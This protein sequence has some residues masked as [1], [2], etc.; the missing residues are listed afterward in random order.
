MQDL[1]HIRIAVLIDHRPNHRG[2]TGGLVGTW[3]HLSRAAAGRS[4]IHL[5]LFFLGDQ[6][7]VIP[8][9]DNVTHVL[10]PPALGTE[11]FFF[12]HSIPTHTD[13]APFHPRLYRSLR[14]YHLLH[15]TD[16]FHAFAKT[17]LW[18]HRISKIPL[19]TSIHTDVIAWARI[20]TPY[21]LQRLIPSSM[22]RKLVIERIRLLDL[23]QLS[24]TRR[25]AGHLRCCRGVFV[26]NKKDMDNVRRLSPRTPVYFLRRG[27]DLELFSPSR[28]DRK[29]LHD[30]MGIPPQRKLLLFV[31][32]LDPVKGAR[33]AAQVTKALLEKGKDVHLLAVG[34][35]SQKRDLVEIL[36]ERVTLTGNLPQSELG[37]IY[38]SSDL[39]LFPSEAEVWPNVVMEAR[40]CGL[41][42]VA[43][44]KG[45]NHVMVGEGVDGILLPTKEV[46]L[47]IRELN[48][49]LENP[50]LLV[51][52]RA[53]ARELSVRSA[54][55]WDQVLEEDL[56]PVWKRCAST[57]EG[58]PLPQPNLK[59]SAELT[60]MRHSSPET[61]DL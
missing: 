57:R 25:L 58:L 60:R 55:S 42:V 6:Q 31:G 37:W 7:R 5:T 43:C 34:D 41:P 45:A 9:A 15:T 46:D 4:D 1:N 20:H 3:E 26:S 39:L 38:A 18:R 14:G 24:M 17:A 21:I 10:L 54:S 44:H 12:L 50:R 8:Q 19:T 35:G 16:A 40:A 32:R 48:G 52:M 13:L 56:I 33:V 30:T 36:G 47:W 23:Q 27:I 28:E 53:K 59:R 49:L 51:Q 2:E 29:R 61:I 22:V 11:R